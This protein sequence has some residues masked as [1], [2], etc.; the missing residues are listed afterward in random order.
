[1][2]LGSSSTGDACDSGM[3]RLIGVPLISRPR[4]GSADRT[5]FDASPRG[6]PGVASSSAPPGSRVRGGWADRGGPPGGPPPA[7]AAGLA[8]EGGRLPRAREP[9]APHDRP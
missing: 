1:M 2:K 4:L 9:D 6:S 5:L 7:S 8:L 3:N